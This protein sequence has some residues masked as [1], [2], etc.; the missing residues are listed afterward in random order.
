[1][2][3]ITLKELKDFLKTHKAIKQYVFAKEA[4]LS[5]FSFIRVKKGETPIEKYM[6]G[7]IKA[8]L[9]YGWE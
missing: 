2:E 4:G 3:D 5:R 7:L 8:M 9:K 6:D 1:M